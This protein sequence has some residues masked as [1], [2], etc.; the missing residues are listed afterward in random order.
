MIYLALLVVLLLVGSGEAAATYDNECHA[1]FSSATQAVCAVT[2]GSGTDRAISASLMMQSNGATS[3]SCSGGG[4]SGWALVSGTDSTSTRTV[5]S[6]IFAAVNPTS[7]AQTITCS[8]TGSVTGEIGVVTVAGANQSAPM[9]NGTFN[10]GTGASAS[11]TVTTTTGDLT[12][13][14]AISLSGH[15]LS[16]PTQT[17]IWLVSPQG[18][19][20]CTGSGSTCAHAWSVGTSSGRV[21]VNAGA[22]FGNAAASAVKHRSTMR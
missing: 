21:W 1:A 14:A 12:I 18:Q 15:A 16:A 5:R 4:A 19:S 11:V 22:R 3:I 13:D 6:M 9:T 20:R 8:W 7:G 10:S 2:V 17:Q